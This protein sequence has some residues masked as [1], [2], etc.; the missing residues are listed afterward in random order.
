[1]LSKL[2]NGLKRL[3]IGFCM[4]YGY[5]LIVPAE[6][7]IPINIVSVIILTIFGIPG[8]LFLIVIRLFVY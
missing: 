6:A 8:L 4:L 3:V 1:M 5:N 7:L 2:V